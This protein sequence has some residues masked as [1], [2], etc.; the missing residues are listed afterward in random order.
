MAVLAARPDRVE[1]GPRAQAPVV[2]AAV[3][4]RVPGPRAEDLEAALQAVASGAAPVAAVAV[5][6]ERAP[7]HPQG[8]ARSVTEA[9]ARVDAGRPADVAGTSKNWKLKS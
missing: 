4:A 3:R 8:E 2:F 1:V 9:A 6:P 5:R 7:V